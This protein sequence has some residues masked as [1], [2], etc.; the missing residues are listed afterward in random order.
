MI[1]SVYQI[2]KSISQ[3]VAQIES[4][5]VNPGADHLL[6]IFFKI[7]DNVTKG[8]KI[9][10]IDYDNSDEAHRLKYPY[11][12][13]PP[14]GSG[15][16]PIAILNPKAIERSLSK[17]I[18]AWFKKELKS[19]SKSK[20][21]KNSDIKKLISSTLDYLNGNHDEIM[22]SLNLALKDYK[23]NKLKFL[24]TIDYDSIEVSEKFTK[25][26]SSKFL[27]EVFD[28]FRKLGGGKGECY[29]CHETKE[30]NG[31]SCPLYVL[32]AR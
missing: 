11:R 27:D 1:E 3:G 25:H 8:H 14:S 6:I 5:L 21:L 13:P 4:A 22:E 29:Y 7:T 31:V 23:L 19:V 18:T 10:I 20:D 16:S 32:Y 24:F 30:V 9:S 28:K 17:K 26:N 12:R 2:G 15:V